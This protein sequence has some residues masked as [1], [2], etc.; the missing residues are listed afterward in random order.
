MKRLVAMIVVAVLTLSTACCSMWK[1][2]P[3][4]W[5]GAT[6]GEQLERLFWDDIKAKNWADLETHLAPMFVANSATATLDRAAAVNRWK[7]FELQSVNLSEI[8]VQ[9]AGADFIVTA[10][11]T[12]TGTASGSPVPVQP[13]RTMTVW[14]QVSKGWVIVAH[15]DTLP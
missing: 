11:L 6:G 3:K 14:Q 7:T 13:I 15:T 8:Q 12:A 9:P 4:G 5:K 10:M 1:N 2:A